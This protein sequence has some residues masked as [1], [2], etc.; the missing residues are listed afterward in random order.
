KYDI[1]TAK[2]WTC[3]STDE[4]Q[5]A[6][7]EYYSNPARTSSRVVVKADG[8]AAGKGVVI[9]G[10]EEQALE[11]VER[12]MVQ[13]VFGDAGSALIIEE[14]LEGEEASIMAFTDGET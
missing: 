1:P 12:M 6:L 2:Y 14:C 10:S 13:R 5:A 11:A 4:A 3:T 8:L 9:A 7:R